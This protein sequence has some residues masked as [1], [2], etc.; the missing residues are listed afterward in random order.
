[1]FPTKLYRLGS[2]PEFVFS[3][4]KEWNHTIVPATDVI[5]HNKAFGLT[6]FIGLDGHAQTA[7]LR[8]TPSYNVRRHLLDIASAISS[9]DDYLKRNK[10]WRDAGV[11]I[12]AHPYVKNEPLGGHIHFSFFL[13]D[14][15]VAELQRCNYVFGQGGWQQHNPTMPYSG[16]GAIVQAKMEQV[17]LAINK[18]ETMS[19]ANFL[20]AM[21]YLLV[22]L[23]HWVQPWATRINRNTK[24]GTAAGDPVRMMYSTRPEMPKYDNW[25]YLHYEYRVPSTWLVHPWLA[26]TYFALAKLTVLNLGPI[27]KM[28]LTPENKKIDKEEKKNVIGALGGIPAPT[29]VIKSL[30]EPQNETF[31]QSLRDRLYAVEQLPKLNR[32]ADL[33]SLQLALRYLA[34]NRE[35]WF[36]P[37]YPVAVEAWRKLI[38]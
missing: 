25:A 1:L 19:P 3:A 5:T 33:D 22:P 24:Y 35:I 34:A 13:N 38:S 6:T 12:Y 16:S 4:V 37:Y 20:I 32:S 2:D 14:P 29:A 28:A 18:R 17:G 36:N 30:E 11:N 26:Y 9:I 8:P 21:N 7:E 15:L 10:K 27:M 31:L 23:E